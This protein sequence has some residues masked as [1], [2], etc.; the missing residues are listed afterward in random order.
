MSIRQRLRPDHESA[1]WLA[2][3]CADARFVYNL[4]LEQRNLWQRHR[5]QKVTTATQMKE[6]A[7]ARQAN[8]WLRSGSSSVQQA[9][10]RDLDR[11]FQNWW[12]SPH[13]FAHPTWRRAGIHEGFYVRD[14]QVRQINGRWGEVSIPKAGWVRF[15]VTRSWASIEAATSARVT[16]DRS[17]RWHVSF[18]TP[19]PAFQRKA[20][21]AEVGLDMGVAA[22]ITTSD[23]V[24][25]WI[26]TLL[27]AGEAQRKHRLQRQLSRQQKGSNR[28]AYT[29]R[30]MA[31]LAAKEADRRRNWIE[32]TTTQ[33]VRNF[34]LIVIEDL[35]VKNMVRSAKGT[36]ANPGRNV[37]Q[38]AGLNRSI[39]AQSWALFR[40]R[41]TDKATHAT[42]LVELVAVNPAYTS[43]RCSDCG[44]A[45]KDNRESQA[46]FRCRACGFTAN[47]DVNAAIN[48]LA[49]G[50]QPVTGRG[51]TSHAPPIGVDQAQR[52]DEASTTRKPL[53][54]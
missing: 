5:L 36:V 33:L 49:A 20:S 23:G 1:A 34:D 24:H 12:K 32:K 41:L 35:R 7:Q 44:Y 22:S 38:K 3:H 29:R 6:L 46:I 43:Q 13:H 8:D 11:A 4:G 37:R 14:L 28:R 31:R 16:L 50:G 48:I 39:H 19:P 42:D 30:C 27:S 15:R 47:A 25:L 26:P 2:K 52:P 21:G 9:A 45:A 53:A 51:G 10:L 40:Q 54:A 18:T 17:G